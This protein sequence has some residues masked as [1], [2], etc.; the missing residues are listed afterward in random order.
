MVSVRLTQLGRVLLG[1]AVVV[2]LLGP[3]L[4]DP[5]LAAGLLLEASGHP[6]VIDMGVRD[7]QAG[8]VRRRPVASGES[9]HDVVP[10]VIARR[11]PGR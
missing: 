8:D 3:L 2:E 7:D 4:L 10:S 1:V 9:R 11:R 5:D 6:V